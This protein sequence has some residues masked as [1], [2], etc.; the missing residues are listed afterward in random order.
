M[1][2]D[3]LQFMWKS[4]MLAHVTSP[5][6]YAHV[7]GC[8]RTAFAKWDNVIKMNV[9]RFKRASAAYP[10]SGIVSCD[11]L[12]PINRDGFYITAVRLLSA[13]FGFVLGALIFVLFAPSDSIGQTMITILNVGLMVLLPTLILIGLISP[14]LPPSNMFAMSFYPTGIRLAH[15]FW[16]GLTPFSC[17]LFTS[18]LIGWIIGITLT[19]FCQYLILVFSIGLATL[20]VPFIFDYQISSPIAGCDSL[21]ISLLVFNLLRKYMNAVRNVFSFGTFSA[22]ALT[23][24]LSL[25]RSVEGIKRLNLSALWASFHIH[26]SLPLVLSIAQ[27]S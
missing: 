8:M 18:F 3:W 2:K 11:D 14:A 20:Y 17:L 15:L 6:S 26:Y 16:V 4:S 10:A 21:P 19:V 7:I 12:I 5:A 9:A 23:T 25:I 27:A 1:G 22:I 13:A 24:I